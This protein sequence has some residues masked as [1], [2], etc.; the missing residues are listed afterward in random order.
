MHK[1]FDLM[2]QEYPNGDCEIH[3]KAVLPAFKDKRYITVDGKPLFVV[4]APLDIPNCKNFWKSGGRW[5]K[6]QD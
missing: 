5:L 1:D 2:L 4:Y 3:F 6:M